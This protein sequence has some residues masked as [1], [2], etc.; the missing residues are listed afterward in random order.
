[1]LINGSNILYFHGVPNEKGLVSFI[2]D[3]LNPV[4]EQI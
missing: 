3:T 2:D 1:M 4:G